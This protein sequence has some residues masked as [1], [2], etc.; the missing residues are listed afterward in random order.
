MLY[1][2]MWQLG[3]Q[4]LRSREAAVAAVAAAVAAAP[5]RMVLECLPFRKV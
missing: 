1:V 4:L 5:G 3:I 2:G